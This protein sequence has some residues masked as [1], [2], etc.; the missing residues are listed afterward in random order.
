MGRR[1]LYSS[2]IN[3]S[4][5]RTESMGWT[6]TALTTPSRGARML[7]SIFMA[8]TTHTSWP[9]ET[10]SPGL[11]RME[12]T[13]PDKGDAIMLSGPLPAEPRVGGGGTTMPGVWVR[14]RRGRL[15]D[16]ADKPSTST[17]KVSPSTVTWTGEW[18]SSPT[19]TLYQFSPTLIRNL[20]TANPCSPVSERGAA[21][22]A[23]THAKS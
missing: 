15:A 19:S 16:R 4:L 8:S 6:R 20:V 23:H 9:V 10:R 5:V 21:P 3:G 13:R 2:S 18:V 14:P 1:W 7:C 22:A 12:I 11:T 17:K